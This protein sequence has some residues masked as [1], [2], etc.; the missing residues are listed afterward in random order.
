MAKVKEPSL[1][2]RDLMVKMTKVYKDFY[3]WNGYCFAGPTSKESRLGTITCQLTPIYKEIF[4][5]FVCTE[6]KKD[7][8]LVVVADA[9]AA[10]DNG[11]MVP[12]TVI[13]KESIQTAGMIGGLNKTT[14]LFQRS[15]IVWTPLSTDEALKQKL[16]TENMIYQKEIIDNGEK[17]H[18]TVA[19]QLLPLVSI[20]NI[21][22]A[23]MYIDDDDVEGTHL[24][25]I[26]IDFDFTHFRMMCIY[27]AV[28]TK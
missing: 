9:K 19:K 3:Y 11:E 21:E 23:Y 5:A 16:Y 20:K 6:D 25:R 24:K 18:I 13:P 28:P 27:H 12:K 4:E 15:D 14:A 1:I 7:V 26:L 2:F 22:K 8:Y 17:K 10:I